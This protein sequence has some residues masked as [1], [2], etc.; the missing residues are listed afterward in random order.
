M[1]PEVDPAATIVASSQRTTA[2]SPLN[3]TSAYKETHDTSKNRKG[4][5]T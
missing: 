3:H 2:R 5:R 1:E 4:E